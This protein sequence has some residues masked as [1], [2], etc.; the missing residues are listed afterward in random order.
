[1]S[2]ISDLT[3]QI[4]DLLEPLTTEER[5]KIFKAVR[6]LLDEPEASSAQQNG[7]GTDEE[8]ESSDLSRQAK[9]WI[10][11][12]GITSSDLE[13]VFHIEGGKVSV[14]AS[15]IPGNSFKIKTINAYILQGLSG[16]LLSG[17]TKF[18]DDAAKELC[19]K[20]GV[21]DRRHHAQYMK[22]FGNKV[23]G[24]KGSGWSLT[25]PGLKYGADLVKEIIRGD[26]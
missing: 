16:F 18:D 1:M 20:S 11:Q 5:Q 10:K 15:A 4:V 17:D 19:T 21:F 26:D 12:N 25:T 8:E 14:I 23:T 9:V 6:A 24:S 13:Q 2:K 3:G 22:E 7:S